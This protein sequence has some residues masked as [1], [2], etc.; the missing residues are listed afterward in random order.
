MQSHDI[1]S[2]PR[3]G[4]IG[5]AASSPSRPPRICFVSFY[6]YPLFHPDCRAPYGGSEVRMSI[7][8]RGLAR[9]G[10]LDVSFVVWDHGQPP[11][12][13]SEGIT[14]YSCGKRVALPV[15][16]PS[17]SA[18]SAEPAR[19][20][21]GGLLRRGARFTIRRARRVARRIEARRDVAGRIGELRVLRSEI[22]LYERIDAD[23]YVIHGN[24]WSA[25]ALSY[26]CAQAKKPLIFFAGSDSDYDPK[27]AEHPG[28]ETIY[29]TPGYVQRKT[30]A[31][32]ALHFS[33]TRAQAERLRR[34]YGKSSI[35]IPNPIELERVASRAAD[36][37][38]VLWVGK[39]DYIKR[40]EL[41]IDLARR[42]PAQRFVLIMSFSS[43]EIHRRIEAEAAE[44]PNVEIQ[45]YVPF[46]DIEQWFARAKLFVSTSRWEGF[47]NTFLQAAKYEV[48]ILSL[49][50]DPDGMLARHGAGVSCG[51]DS[52]RLSA[53][54]SRL[55]E[56]P[57]ERAAV[58][59]RGLDYVRRNHDADRA[60]DQVERA[61][62]AFLGVDG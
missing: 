39:S 61:L 43:A 22:A 35:V 2:A 34:A 55:L 21:G 25:A 45:R 17:G 58:G 44:L 11:I 54:L 1:S 24:T 37:D 41:A 8:A 38:I 4:P 56:D 5:P 18:P 36:P 9:R 14:F 7:L 57:A 3:A 30:I 16:P 50:V 51:D 62:T 59:A 31:D 42:F 23:A 26:Y 33:Q 6:V 10:K 53:E 48:P 47:P 49:A 12:D 52:E 19:E 27:F 13:R 40:P 60:I 20:R 28:E 46:T 32:A 29:G 15:E